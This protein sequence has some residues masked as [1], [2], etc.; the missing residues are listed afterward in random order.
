MKLFFFFHVKHQ[1]YIFFLQFFCY[2]FF[3]VQRAKSRRTPPY[4]NKCTKIARIKCVKFLIDPLLIF[5]IEN[6]IVFDN[7]RAIF[8]DNIPEKCIHSLKYASR[9]DK[10][11]ETLDSFIEMIL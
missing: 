1:K 4:K 8:I 2:S 5:A 7:N 6:S 10:S 11:R 9:S 3:T